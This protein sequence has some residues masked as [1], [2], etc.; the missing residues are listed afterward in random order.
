YKMVSF[1][2]KHDFFLQNN[3]V[4]VKTIF[5]PIHTESSEFYPYLS[6]NLQGPNTDLRL[7]MKNFIKIPKIMENNLQTAIDHQQGAIV[8]LNIIASNLSS[9]L[10]CIAEQTSTDLTIKNSL[11]DAINM[12][13]DESNLPICLSTF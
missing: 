6:N 13:S 1:H 3:P 10:T 4:E 2:E 5:P 8:F 9:V 7:V 12:L 11:H